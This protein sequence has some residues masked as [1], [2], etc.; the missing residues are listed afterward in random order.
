MTTREPRTVIA[1]ASTLAGVIATWVVVAS[2]TVPKAISGG[3]GDYGFFTGIADRLREGAALYQDV[4]DN[5]DPFVFYSIAI[6]R[7]A[8]VSGVWLLEV[9]WILLASAAVHALARSEG[10][11][12]VYAVAVAWIA[13]PV[14]IV[15]MPYFMGS[16]HLPGVALTLC[17]VALVRRGHWVLAGIP[18]GVLIFF[19]FVMLPLALAVLVTAAVTQRRGRELWGSAIGFAGTTLATSLVMLVRG[20]FGGFVLTQW[21]NIRYSQSPIVAADYVSPFQKVAQHIVILVNPNVLAILMA[22][23]II[24]VFA[25]IVHRRRTDTG[26]INQ[27]SLWWITLVA[28]A[29]E[30]ATIAVTGKWFHHAEIFAVSSVLGLILLSAALLEA[31]F[32]LVA[33]IGVSLLAV[34]LLAA[35]P[36]LST[37]R[38][39][40]TSVTHFWEQAERA[41]D[42]TQIL[43]E[44]EPTSIAL[45]GWGNRIPRSGGLAGWNFTCRHLAQRPFNPQW[46]FDE[47]LACLPTADLIIVTNDYGPD[48][49]FPAYIEFVESVERLLSDD[50]T[51]STEGDF[52]ICRR[53]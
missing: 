28:L 32:W 38:Y 44:E 31:K 30:V 19:K 51:C 25:A 42:L 26:W 16:T 15:G 10:L 33:R 43:G 22:T 1:W 8:G 49:A 37:Y 9:F 6:A 12:R 18:L 7:S 36:P 35:A 45:V 50:Y 20:E 24:L 14:V 29:V 13:A 17:M 5:K 46:M 52:R 53:T 39:A 3:V 2:V 34:F 40:L 47:T 23:A 41:D 21:D 11:S 27:P 4:W 48:P